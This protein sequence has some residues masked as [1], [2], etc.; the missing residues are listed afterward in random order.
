MA[1][2]RRGHSFCVITA[3]GHAARPDTQGSVTVMSMTQSLLDFILD[4]LRDSDAKAA[5]LA[6]PDRALADAGLSN[7]CSED[8]SDA[9]SY[10]SEYHPVAL[11]GPREYNLGN[12]A[13]V[14]HAEGHRPEHHEGWHDHDY[15]PD[16]HAGVIQ[17]LEY[18]T[19]NYAY[20]D[21]HDTVIDK[22]VNQSIWNEGK[23]TQT[24]NDNSVT[25]TDHSVAAGRDISGDVANGDGNVVG[26]NA[27]VGNT[28]NDYSTHGSFN[29]NNIADRGGIAGDGNVTDSD[30]SDVAT[31]GSRVDDSRED[32]HNTTIKDVGNTYDSD[33]TTIKDSG[34]NYHNSN[35]TYDSESTYDHSGNTYHHEHVAENS[36]NTVESHNED[37]AISSTHQEGLLN[38]AVSPAVNVPIHDNDILSNIH[39]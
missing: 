26:D 1:G 36:F 24:F 18:I 13:V 38:L 25:A 33:N 11:V 34:N 12:T 31:N 22:S 4:L 14:Q 16:P 39:G 8:I 3:G 30:H 32:I 27:Q 5:F 21:S 9:M 7:V 6:D 15:W 10:V 35:N 20:T 23:L 37:S 17:Q 29:G 28:S 19:N 2:Y